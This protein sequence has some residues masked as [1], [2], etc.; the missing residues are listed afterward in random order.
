MMGCAKTLH[1]AYLFLQP[2]HIAVRGDVP[3][4]NALELL[5]VV[6]VQVSFR[7]AGTKWLALEYAKLTT[8]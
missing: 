5:R 1:P 4:Q 2:D 8:L 3:L 7:K 6:R